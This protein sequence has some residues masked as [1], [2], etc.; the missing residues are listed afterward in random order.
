MLL[1][2][3]ARVARF[4]ERYRLNA[5]EFVRR[6][7]PNTTRKKGDEFVDWA[8]DIISKIP[9]LPSILSFYILLDVRD[10]PIRIDIPNW[11]YLL[12]EIGW[13]KPVDVSLQD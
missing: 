13:P 8:V 6:S 5:E 9:K 1:G 7:F 4:F 3:S 12:S 11:E 10:S 2:P